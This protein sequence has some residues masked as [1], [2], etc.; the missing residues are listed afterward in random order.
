MI[1]KIE[2]LHKKMKGFEPSVKARDI[3]AEHNLKLPTVY[4]MAARGVIPSE[5]LGRAVRFKRSKV[6]TAIERRSR[7]DEE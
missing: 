5:K 4:K 7:H 3:A 6:Q 1:E 2:A